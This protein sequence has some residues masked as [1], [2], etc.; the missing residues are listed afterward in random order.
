MPMK[1]NKALPGKS[2]KY[3][4]MVKTGAMKG[5]KGEY[6]QKAPDTSL[7]ENLAGSNDRHAPNY[8]PTYPSVQHGGG[9]KTSPNS[10]SRGKQG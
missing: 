7:R 10:S 8:A 6:K 2:S 1:D 4:G 3:A 5:G 9:G